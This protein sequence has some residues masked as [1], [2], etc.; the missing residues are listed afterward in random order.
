[1]LQLLWLQLLPLS[2]M[3]PP[4]VIHSSCSS[5][6][7]AT[8]DPLGPLLA[9]IT[10]ARTAGA[11]ARTGSPTRIN[12]ILGR[13]L[14]LGRR[15]RTAAGRHRIPIATQAR[16]VTITVKVI[17]TPNELPIP[18]RL[19]RIALP[20]VLLQPT[21]SSQVASHTDQGKVAG[22]IDTP[23]RQTCTS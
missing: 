23:R 3:N 16:T 7:L 15:M 18:G 14:G 17:V 13:R 20:P 22:T 10:L 9:H 6:H 8:A 2:T 11:R 19:T 12:R 5:N 4:R 21:N 1:M